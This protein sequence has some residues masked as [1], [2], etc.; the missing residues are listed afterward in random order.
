MEFF[1]EELQKVMIIDYG[2][3]PERLISIPM[4]EYMRLKQLAKDIEKQQIEDAFDIACSDQDR[5]GCEYYNQTYGG[6]K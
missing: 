1:D 2:L 3:V 5:I 6:N 4:D